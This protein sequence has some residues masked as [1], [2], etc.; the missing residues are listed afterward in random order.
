[1]STLEGSYNLSE[2]DEAALL[3]DP[4][5]HMLTITMTD[6]EGTE[7]VYKFSTLTSQKAYITVNGNGG[8]YVVPSRVKKF[9]SDTQKFF[10]FE[11]VDPSAKN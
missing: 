9:I 7:T 11:L 2:E 1:M 10:N 3:A 5:K 6:I 8:F 4:T